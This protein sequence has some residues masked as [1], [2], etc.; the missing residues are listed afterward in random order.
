MRN[1]NNNNNNNNKSNN[2]YRS[3]EIQ[4]RLAHESFGSDDD[5]DL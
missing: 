3:A 5:P 1:N 4:R 2:L